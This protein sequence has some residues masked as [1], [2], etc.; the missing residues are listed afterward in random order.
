M[1]FNPWR[2]FMT[3]SKQRLSALAGSLFLA[4]GLMAT[5]QVAAEEDAISAG[6]K[7]AFD[8]TKGN[9]LACHH[10]E[11]GDLMGNI[12]PPLVAMKH[13]FPDKAKLRAQIWNASEANPVTI[14]PP[15]GKHRI[16]SDKEIDLVTEFIYSL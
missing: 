6:K 1:P 3:S 16:L 2:M 14:M 9:C 11:G 13:R 15:F 7:L 12:A 10:I 5:T 8:R 4:T